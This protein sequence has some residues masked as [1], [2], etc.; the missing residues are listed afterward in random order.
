MRLSVDEMRLQ[1]ELP[2][3]LPMPEQ[4]PARAIA[5]G[6]LQSPECDW[7]LP[8]WGWRPGYS[9]RMLERRFEE[10]CTMSFGRW[11]QMAR[12]LA[13]LLKLAGGAG[14]LNAALSCGYQSPSAFTKSFRD[15]FGCAP[16]S[17]FQAH[18]G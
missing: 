17:Y 1:P 12:L 7:T 8:E 5:Q 14:V 18:D 10:Q 9:A 2:F 15:L 4:A 6:L 13:G 11:R 3:F 16:A